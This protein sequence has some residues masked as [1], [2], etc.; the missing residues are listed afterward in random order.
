MDDSL[1]KAFKSQRE[2][3]IR[4]RWRDREF[5]AFCS[6]GTMVLAGLVLAAFYLL[7]THQ[8]TN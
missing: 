5:K 7:L 3:A 4:R 1:L 8:V 2:E 6:G